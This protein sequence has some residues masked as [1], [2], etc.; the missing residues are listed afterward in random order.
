MVDMK[1]TVRELN[2]IVEEY[3]SRIR[4]ISNDEFTAKPRIEKWSKQEVMGH[5]VDSAHN[6]LR[7]FIVGQ[8]DETSN[9]VYDQD[10]WVRANAF[11]NANK[12]EIVELWRLLN[13]RI[14]AVLS[15]MPEANYKRQVN[16]GSDSLQLQSLEWLASDYLKHMK[17]HLNQVFSRAF[18][19]TYP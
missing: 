6:N 9:V 8:Y 10:F 2:S 1:D 14:C 18:D 3:A 17:H 11:Q 12:D 13:R 16:T 19:I 4:Q 7:R 15:E 5:L